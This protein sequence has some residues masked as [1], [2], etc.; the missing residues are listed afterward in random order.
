MYT[1]LNDLKA[2][3]DKV[4]MGSYSQ[5]ALRYVSDEDE[6]GSLKR[7]EIE[8]VF[9]YELYFEWRV[10]I[11]QKKSYYKELQLNG[12][13][14]KPHLLY[15]QEKIDFDDFG[16][17]N[18]YPN[19][20]SFVPDLTLHK[21]QES[22]EYKDQEMVIEIKTDKTPSINDIGKLL[23]LVDKYNFKMGVFLTVNNSIEDLK[24]SIK[25]AFNL[26]TLKTKLVTHE[27]VFQ[28]I[29]ILNKQSPSSELFEIK[30]LNFLKENIKCPT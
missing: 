13:V 29:I 28:R 17:V 20:F 25:T 26:D 4:K 7:Q 19:K 8:R 23:N 10:I 14:S 22:I 11:E 5:F 16:L 27:K 12:E 15:L 2:A 1:F 18:Y 24:E 6:I 9:S 21:G 30:L 3:I